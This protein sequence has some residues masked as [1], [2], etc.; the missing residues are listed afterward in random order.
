MTKADYSNI[1]THLT[2]LQMRIEKKIESLDNK[3]CLISETREMIRNLET[4]DEI[5]KFLKKEKR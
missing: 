5:K 4:L 1:K 3:L 2:I